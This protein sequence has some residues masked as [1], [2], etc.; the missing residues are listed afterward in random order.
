MFGM[1]FW[2]GLI[3]G[4]CVAMVILL[5]VAMDLKRKECKERNEEVKRKRKKQALELLMN[6]IE[7]LIDM[8][9]NESACSTRMD[10]AGTNLRVGGLVERV[11]KLEGLSQAK[12]DGGE[13]NED[14]GSG[15]NKRI[16]KA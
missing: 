14:G 13:C 15:K 9:V 12:Q 5:L 6:D 11:K 16:T 2:F 1:D 10:L 3:I 4:V 8:K 7:V